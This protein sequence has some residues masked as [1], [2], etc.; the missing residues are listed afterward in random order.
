MK[1]KV[2]LTL[3]V[4]LALVAP[5]CAKHLHKEAWYQKSW[6]AEAGGQTEVKFE[7]GTRCD[8]LTADH[9]IEFDFG[10]KWAESIGQA[11]YYSLQ[12]GKRAGIVLILET[13]DDYRYW[14]RL[15][16]TIMHHNLPIDTWKMGPEE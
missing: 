3:L 14:L 4:V 15:N 9:A 13:Q 7:D 1:L 10:S 16:S 5:A 11:L 6:C 8:C 12:T 2:L